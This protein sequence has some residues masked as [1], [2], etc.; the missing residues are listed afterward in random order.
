MAQKRR[1]REPQRMDRDLV[2]AATGLVILPIAA[3]AGFRGGTKPHPTAFLGESGE[4]GR[5][6]PPQIRVAANRGDF[7]AGRWQ[8]RSCR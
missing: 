6:R 3:L 5:E 1:L 8:M 2:C 7:A 4:R